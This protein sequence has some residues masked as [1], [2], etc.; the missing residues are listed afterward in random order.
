MLEIGKDNK[1]ELLDEPLIRNA[2]DPITECFGT[3]EFV[4]LICDVVTKEICTEVSLQD[5]KKI[6]FNLHPAGAKELGVALIELAALLS[7][8]KTGDQE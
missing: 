4:S 5:G 8:A 2:V 6:A 7:V 1:P 3:T